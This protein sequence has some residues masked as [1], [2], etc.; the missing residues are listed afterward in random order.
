MDAYHGFQQQK[1]WM[2]SGQIIATSRDL[3]PKWR[4]TSIISRTSTRSSGR[5]MPW[6]FQKNLDWWNIIY[7]LARYIWKIYPPHPGC[8]VANLG[9]ADPKRMDAL[10]S[11][12]F[13][14]TFSPYLQPGSEDPAW[15]D[16]EKIVDSLFWPHLVDNSERESWWW[17]KKNS[18]FSKQWRDFISFRWGGF[19]FEIFLPQVGGMIEFHDHIFSS[20]VETTNS[21]SHWLIVWLTVLELFQQDFNQQI[22]GTVDQIGV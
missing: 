9:F 20:L 18:F 6:K 8:Q 16:A 1:K 22:V 13:F 15:K 14:P 19:K 10:K 21:T 4:E 12:K 11:R 2:A 7:N 5:E 3:T 17:W